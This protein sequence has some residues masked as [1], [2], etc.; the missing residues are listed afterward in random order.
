M[1]AHILH[2]FK[3]YRMNLMDKISNNVYNDELNKHILNIII[4]YLKY[5]GF[6]RHEILI[7]IILIISSTAA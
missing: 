5:R 7:M 6:Y 3:D 1:L 4:L 2:R